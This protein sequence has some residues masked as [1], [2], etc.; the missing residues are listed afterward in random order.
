MKNTR[1]QNEYCLLGLW[2]AHLLRR[3]HEFVSSIKGKRARPADT[4]EVCRVEKFA[5]PPI[6][7]SKAV[8]YWFLGA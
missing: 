1:V 2:L 6:K 3:A 8:M 4:M 7:G 5:S